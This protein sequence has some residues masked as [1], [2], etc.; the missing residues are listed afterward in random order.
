MFT[1]RAW[2][3]LAT[4]GMIG[5]ACARYSGAA[6]GDVGNI[7]PA[8]AA[9][10]VVL[11]SV[12]PGNDAMELRIIVHGQSRFVGS[13]G[14]RDSSDVLLDPSIFPTGE[15]YVIAI[16]ADGHGRTGSGPLA[17]A[18]GNRIRFMIDPSLGPS[19]AVVTP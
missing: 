2:L 18:K 12:N 13:V 15:L 3:A 10:T 11:R 14:P 4:T 6:A 1:K 5:A 7:D 19:R 9:K 8:D 17:A 16:P